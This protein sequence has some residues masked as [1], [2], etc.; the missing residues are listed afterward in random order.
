[1]H[2]LDA[3][4]KTV[5]PAPA[6]GQHLTFTLDGEAY[7]LPILAV[8]EIKGG[9]PVTRVPNTPAYVRGVMNLR[10][11]IVPVID[12]RTRLGLP[13]AAPEAFAVIVVV[14]VAGRSVGLIVDA[15]SDVLDLAGGDLEPV[16]E[17]GGDVDP[18]FITGVARAGDRLILLLN[19]E[20]VLGQDGPAGVAGPPGGGQS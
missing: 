10:G 9:A 11:T 5:A 1:M 15:V 7:A 14:M 19:L 4:R 6:G 3:A 16:P 8:Q 12:L 2:A 13:E 17:F 20:R 18:R